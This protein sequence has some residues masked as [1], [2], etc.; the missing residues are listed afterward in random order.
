M[1]QN[2]IPFR[3]T[4]KEKTIDEAMAA[5]QKRVLDE[6]FDGDESS[7]QDAFAEASTEQVLELMQA[8]FDLGGN[9]IVKKSL[10]IKEELGDAM[11]GVM[12][13]WL[14]EHPSE[15]EAL[16]LEAYRLN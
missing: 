15:D 11:I 12:Q 5:L 3:T 9:D 4:V 13:Q 6:V 2:V 14:D 1:G 8:M 10:D 7:Y 16:V